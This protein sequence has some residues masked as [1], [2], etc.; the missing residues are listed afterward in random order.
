[1]NDRLKGKKEQMKET[2]QKKKKGLKT[3][4]KRENADR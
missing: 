2:E 4:R 3:E 1:M